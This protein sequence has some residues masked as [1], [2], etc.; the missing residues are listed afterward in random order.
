[1]VFIKRCVQ[2]L[3]MILDE[4]F[5]KKELLRKLWQAPATINWFLFTIVYYRII[6]RMATQIATQIA[7]L[8]EAKY[9]LVNAVS[10]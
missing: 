2:A 4:N 6:K 8:M 5:Q 1:M 3:E 9:R 10:Q 7:T